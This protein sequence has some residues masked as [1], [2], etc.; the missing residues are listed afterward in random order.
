MQLSAVR[1]NWLACGAYVSEG[2]LINFVIVPV[3][4]IAWN[5]DPIN[6]ISIL[7]NDVFELQKYLHSTPAFATFHLNFPL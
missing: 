7:L 2:S 4:I 5:R 3:L 6:D 1:I